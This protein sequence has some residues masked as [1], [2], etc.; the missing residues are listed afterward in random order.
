MFPGSAPHPYP[1]FLLLRHCLCINSSC[2]HEI[3]CELFKPFY[4]KEVI[5]NDVFQTLF[6][7]LKHQP[8]S[9]QI[10][11]LKYPSAYCNW[12]QWHRIGLL[13]SYGCLQKALVWPS[14]FSTYIFLSSYLSKGIQDISPVQCSSD[15]NGSH[16]S[17]P[18]Q[19]LWDHGALAQKWS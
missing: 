12:W 11:S 16:A 10:S 3:I 1:H 19:F 13:L 14:P 7:V 9:A 17:K 15:S 8:T 6:T 4:T 5:H 18:V 2:M